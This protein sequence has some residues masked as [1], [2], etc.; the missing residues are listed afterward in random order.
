MTD[1]VSVGIAGTAAAVAILAGWLQWPSPPALDGE[2]WFK[3]ILATVLRG[4]V[5]DR[6]GTFEEWEGRVLKFVPYHPLGRWPERKVTQPRATLPQARVEGEQ[7]LM[8]HLATLPDLPSRWSWMFDEDPRGREARLIDPVEL[9]DAYDP[10]VV[11]QDPLGWDALA[12]WGGGDSALR[13]RVVGRLGARWVLFESNPDLLA[14]PSVTEVL[15][16][17]LGDVERVPWQEA[18]VEEQVL[19]ATRRILEDRGPGGTPLVLVGEGTGAAVMMRAMAG[20]VG[21]RDATIG[22]LSIGG[23]IGGRPDEAGPFGEQVAQDWLGRWFTQHHLDSEVVRKNPWMSL[24]WLDRQA[25]V[26]GSRGLPLGSQRF[27]EPR[28]DG[29]QPTVEVVD[30]GVLPDNDDLPL[31]QVARALVATVSL[32]LLTRR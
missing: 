13:E 27:P 6:E 15:A 16:E 20:D 7:A 29:V 28:D 1:P 18:P 10:A 5:E 32:W 23:V 14:G 22:V 8:D 3:V 17:V 24:Q 26:P 19:E 9:G 2:R 31:D 21:L 4:E 12:R 30:L 25:E 11:L